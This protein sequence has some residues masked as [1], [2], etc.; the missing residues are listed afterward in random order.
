[1]L[2]TEEKNALKKAFD[3]GKGIGKYGSMTKGSSDEIDEYYDLLYYFPHLKGKLISQFE[4][5]Q[6]SS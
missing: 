3:I 5:G 6:H 4:K 1:M 2:G